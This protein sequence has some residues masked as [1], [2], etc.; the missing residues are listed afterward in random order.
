MDTQ[1]SFY[2]RLLERNYQHVLAILFAIEEV[3]ANPQLLPNTTLGYNVY[4][5]Y[6]SVRIPYEATIDLLSTDHRMVPNFKCGRQEKSLAVIQGGE[7][8]DFIQMVTMLGIYKVPQVWM[9]GWDCVE[10][11]WKH[12]LSVCLQSFNNVILGSCHRILRTTSPS[13]VI[14]V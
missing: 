3:N 12:I 8:E 7:F 10:Q 4:E 1:N 5:N 11:K 14:V 13:L 9:G 6:L 2:S